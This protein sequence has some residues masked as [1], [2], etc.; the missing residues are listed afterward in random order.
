MH[1]NLP[2]WYGNLLYLGFM[3]DY[4]IWGLWESTLPSI[5]GLWEY[6]LPGVYDN[7]LY[8]G[9]MGI[10]STHG[11]IVNIP[12]LGFMGIYRTWG[13]IKFYSSSGLWKST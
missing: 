11:V 2:K 1:G 6:K 13:F 5:W 4:P 3:A 9:L 10:Y 8:L 7:L 12:Y